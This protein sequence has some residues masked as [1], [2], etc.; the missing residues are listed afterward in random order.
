MAI[1]NDPNKKNPILIDYDK[2]ATDK[3]AAMKRVVGIFESNGANVVSAEVDP[4]PRRVANYTFR[5]VH[6]T[7]PDSQQ[8]T[9]GVTQNG[10]IYQVKINNKVFAIHNQHDQAES[11]KEIVA[12]LDRGRSSWQ[13]KLALIKEPSPSKRVTMSLKQKTTDAQARLATANEAVAEAAAQER[14]LNEQLQTLNSN[15]ATVLQEIQDL[16]QQIT[17]AT[18]NAA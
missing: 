13:K 10:D 7:F 9:F 18:G 5:L 17:S 15:K 4:K 2:L 3:D 14:A 12:A 1:V 11:V 8:V 16:E 6:L